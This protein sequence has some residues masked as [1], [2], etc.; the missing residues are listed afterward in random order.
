MKAKIFIQELWQRILGWDE[1][2]PTELEAKWDD[3][4]Q[5]IQE[6]AS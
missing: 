3:I 5:D 2:L 4:A 6:L 1:P